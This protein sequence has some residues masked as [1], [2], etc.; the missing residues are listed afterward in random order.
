MRTTN[1]SSVN[2]YNNIK[3]DR[4]SHIPFTLTFLYPQICATI[5]MRMLQLFIHLK[6]L[7]YQTYQQVN[8]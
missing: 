5:Y 7:K 6:N 3:D 8:K 2:F 4:N 1:Y